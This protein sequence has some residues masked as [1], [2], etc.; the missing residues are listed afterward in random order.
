MHREPYVPSPEA[1]ERQVQRAVDQGKGRICTDPQI[2][3][4]VASVLRPLPVKKAS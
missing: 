3:R 1:I 4:L 2:L